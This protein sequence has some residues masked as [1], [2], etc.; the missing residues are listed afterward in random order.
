[1]YLLSSF[2]QRYSPRLNN[3]ASHASK[4]KVRLF[5]SNGRQAIIIPQKTKM[6]KIWW[7][8]L[9]GQ[10]PLRTHCTVRVILAANFHLAL[11]FPIGHILSKY[12]RFVLF[13]TI[14]AFGFNTPLC[15]LF[16][17]G[18]RFRCYL[19][20]L[21]VSRILHFRTQRKNILTVLQN[22]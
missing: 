19:G 1:M 2:L 10:L 17:M 8:H 18:L 21:T 13:L 6:S 20:Y 12:L 14:F 7:D 11:S 16:S 3:G 5:S 15:C 22:D 9:F 4:W